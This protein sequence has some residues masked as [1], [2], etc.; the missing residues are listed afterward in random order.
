MTSLHCVSK[1]SYKEL[2]KQI[3]D[4]DKTCCI[5]T[6][7]HHHIHNVANEITF[8]LLYVRYRKEN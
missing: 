7:H 3:C 5:T 8:G 6:L 1:V 4:S 2:P